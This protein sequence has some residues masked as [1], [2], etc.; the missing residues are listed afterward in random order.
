MYELL[1]AVTSEVWNHHFVHAELS[2]VASLVEVGK[3]R[4]RLEVAVVVNLGVVPE[5][6]ALE[7]GVHRIPPDVVC[8]VVVVAIL[9]ELPQHFPPWNRVIA[10]VE[11]DSFLYVSLLMCGRLDAI[12]FWTAYSL[13][14]KTTSLEN[15]SLWKSL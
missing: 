8:H 2:F 6:Q 5:M 11:Q 3:N 4:P 10:A 9:L 12:L 14:W 13:D 15:L 1:G 7:H